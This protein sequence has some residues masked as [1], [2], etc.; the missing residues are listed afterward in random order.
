MW[1]TFYKWHEGAWEEDL[2]TNKKKKKN[3]PPASYPLIHSPYYY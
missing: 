2:G 3:C 1:I